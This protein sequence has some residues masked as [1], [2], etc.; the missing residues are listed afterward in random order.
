MQPL[1][2][3]IINEERRPRRVP[4]SGLIPE[5]W[6][7]RGEWMFPPDCYQLTLWELPQALSFNTN[8]DINW[9]FSKL[10]DRMGALFEHE[11]S[12]PEFDKLY[13]PT[14]T[15]ELQAAFE[16]TCKAVGLEVVY[17]DAK[18]LSK[19]LRSLTGRTT[20]SKPELQSPPRRI[21]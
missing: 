16:H 6:A 11:V 7:V 12:M 14:L 20:V 1:I 18:N 9:D 10:E 5:G 8:R 17:D 3:G 4:P 2:T 21:K 19:K 15:R 13:C